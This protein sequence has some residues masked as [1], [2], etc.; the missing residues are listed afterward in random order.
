MKRIDAAAA[1]GDVASLHRAVH[2]LRG[3]VS[4]YQ[5]HSSLQAVRELDG[6]ARKGELEEAV[7][8]LPALRKELARLGKELEKFKKSL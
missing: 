7:S 3:M 8:L 1:S 2:A 6:H 5:S 4:N